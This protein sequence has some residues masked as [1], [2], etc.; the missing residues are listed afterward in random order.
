M[1]KYRVSVSQVA[2]DDVYVDAENEKEACKKVLDNNRWV[3]EAP[4]DWCDGHEDTRKV[5]MVVELDDNFN[6]V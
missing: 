3:A 6:E 5:E 2:C 1:K 4:D